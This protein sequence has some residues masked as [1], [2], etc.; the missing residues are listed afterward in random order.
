MHRPIFL[1]YTNQSR[2]CI[3]PGPRKFP[4]IVLA[5]CGQHPPKRKR[6]TAM[7]KRTTPPDDVFRRVRACN[8]QMDRS[9]DTEIEDCWF[10]LKT[11]NPMVYNAILHQGRP[12]GALFRS[13]VSTIYRGM[14]LVRPDVVPILGTIDS[15]AANCRAFHRIVDMFPCTFMV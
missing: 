5:A 13:Y 15:L 6:P 3:D 2:T 12:N 7:Q 1:E 4:W 9:D 11:T 8:C 14:H 10:W